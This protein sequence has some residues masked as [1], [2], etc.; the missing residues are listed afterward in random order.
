MGS[1]RVRHDLTAKQ[2]QKHVD[3]VIFVI[4]KFPYYAILLQIL[5]VIKTEYRSIAKATRTLFIHFVYLKFL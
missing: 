2:Q 1:Q 5:E 4:C 3:L